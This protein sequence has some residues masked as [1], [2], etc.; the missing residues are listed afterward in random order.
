VRKE[1]FLLKRTGGGSPTDY[2]ILKAKSHMYKEKEKR[3]QARLS[4]H[5]CI[6]GMELSF[7]FWI[8]K[9][10]SLLNINKQ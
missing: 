2:N 10:N 6:S 5:D 4:S 1:I 3:N 9:V 7:A 8:T